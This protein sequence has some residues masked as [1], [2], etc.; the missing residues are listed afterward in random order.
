MTIIVPPQIADQIIDQ[1]IDRRSI[2]AR[3]K[4][5]IEKENGSANV[6]EAAAVPDP[7]LVIVIVAMSL[8]NT[9]KTSDRRSPTHDEARPECQR[10]WFTPKFCM[11]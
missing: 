5:Y 4:E 2:T 9:K 11:T 6:E 8:K 10:D 1:I 3:T 7:G